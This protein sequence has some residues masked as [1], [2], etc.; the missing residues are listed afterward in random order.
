MSSDEDRVWPEYSAPSWPHLNINQED[1]EVGHDI[2][3]RVCTFW[4]EIIPLFLPKDAP[5]A[6]PRVGRRSDAGCREVQKR[7]RVYFPGYRP[8]HR[9]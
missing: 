8:I 7:A 4:E 5:M 6:T 2:R 1:L 3:A 9:L